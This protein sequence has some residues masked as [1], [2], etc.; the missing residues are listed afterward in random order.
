MRSNVLSRS[1]LVLFFLLNTLGIRTVASSAPTTKTDSREA[2]EASPAST[3]SGMSVTLNTPTHKVIRF[4]ASEETESAETPAQETQEI[5]HLVLKRNGVLTP[6]FERTLEIELSNVPVYAPGI[7]VNL[8]IS[9]QHKDPDHEG[10]DGRSIQVWSE[11]EFVPHTALTQQGVNVNFSVTFDRFMKR[12]GMSTSTPTDYYQYQVTITDLNGNLRQSHTERFAFLMENQWRVP[13]PRLLEAEP[14]SAPDRLL[15]YYYDMIPFQADMR[16]PLTQIPREAVDRYI[17]TELVPAMVEAVRAQTNDWGF[18]WYPE[19]RNFRR[20]EDP[21]TLSVALGEYGVWYHGEAPT[22]GHS[23]ISIRVDGS[24]GEYNNLTEGIMSVFHHELFH[25]QQRNISLHFNN[26]GNVAGRDEAWKMFSEGTAVLA[27]SIGQSEVQFEQTS[28]MRSYMKRAASYIGVEGVFGGGLNMS[29][30]RIPYHT[31]AYWRFLYEA[32]GGLEDTAT[33]MS[34]IRTVLETLY[35]GEVVD[36]HTATNQIESLPAVMDRALAQTSSCPFG[37]H[38]ESLAEFARTIYMLRTEDGRCL[39]PGRTEC[40][41]FDPNSLYPM[42]PVERMTVA[43]RP[44]TFLDGNIPSSYGI[45][46]VELDVDASAAG[47]S[48]IIRFAKSSTSQAEFAVSVALVKSAGS[49]GED[50]LPMLVGE[51][52]L[53]LNENGELVLE[54]GSIDLGEFDRIGLIVVRT[55]PNENLDPTGSYALQI[56]TH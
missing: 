25:N 1:L 8:T 13:L 47:K 36:V 40:G 9:T 28:A 21:K 18:A 56:T 33:G 23:M 54:V 52:E 41:L 15:V 31:A 26:N 42:P 10:K 32:C 30:A 49:T 7:H 51:T 19:W 44:V 20:D 53:S 39:E 45:D 37:S 4:N 43:N 6:G 35:M 16:D 34:V 50:G 46:F 22:L 29:Y 38:S 27:S 24:A 55:D 14:G 11:R 12:D 17:Q 3:Y 48:L 5:P 2:W